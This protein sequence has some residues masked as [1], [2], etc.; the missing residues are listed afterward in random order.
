MDF[1]Y[2]QLLKHD[3]SIGELQR[4]YP[5]MDRVLDDIDSLNNFKK[6]SMPDIAEGVAKGTVALE[7]L[8]ELRVQHNDFVL[9][10]NQ[11]AE[12][13]RGLQK[14]VEQLKKE[15]AELRAKLK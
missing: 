4:L 14:S 7:G 10:F 15:N 9:N 3:K 13:I 12:I 2:N 6:L 8:Q 1:V 5:T 11:W